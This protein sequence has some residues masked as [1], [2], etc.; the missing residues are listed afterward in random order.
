M[1]PVIDVLN[2]ATS[3]TIGQMFGQSIANLFSALVILLVGWLVAIVVA[4]VV[5]G[6]FRRVRLDERIAHATGSAEGEAAMPITDWIG[7]GVF[8][9]IMLFFI[10]GALEAMGMMALV[11]P[12]NALVNQVIA[13]LPKLLGAAVL[14]LVA[15]VIG[16]IARKLVSSV[17]SSRRIDE[18]L[19][20][21]TGQETSIA[22]PL[23]EAA[24]YLVW[25]FFLP[26]ILGALGLES[27]LVPVMNMIDQFL[28]F[29]PF[30]AA[31][32]ILFVVGWFAA[33]IV[34]RV[35]TGFL[36]STGI[37]AAAERVGIAKYMGGVTVSSLL[38]LFV[39]ILVLIP[40]VTASLDALNLQSLTEPLTAMLNEVFVAIPSYIAAIAILIVTFVVARWFLAIVVNILAGLG[41]NALPQALGIS[42][43]DRIGGRTPA[44]WVGDVLL[45]IVMLLATVQA[46]Q[47][48]G[49]TAITVAVGR[50][51]TQIVQIV[52]GLLIVAVGVYVAN[53]A[54]RFIEGTSTPNKGLLVAA[55]RVSIIAFIGA[56]GLTA[57]GVAEPIVIIA[58]GLFFGAIAVA[59]ALAFGLGGRES[60][61]RAVSDWSARIDRPE[62]DWSARIDRQDQE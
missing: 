45:L 53:L 5:K 11:E 58:F 3:Q 25:L 40:V 24:Y 4:K 61:A 57:M 15:H 44:Q 7:T 48:V 10:M 54:A 49:W 6:I 32:A 16:S 22:S 36:A 39:F 21:G 34:Q 29:L 14:A 46:A 12:I 51:G 35:V 41:I 56:M 26:A 17:A 59:V 23:G 60:A 37:D 42:D 19:S 20:S 31:G 27:L 43:S 33:R 18:R 28:A 55:A 50:L 9:L 1:D 30:L 52:F 38:G 2:Q 62:S 8:W 47:L 13:F